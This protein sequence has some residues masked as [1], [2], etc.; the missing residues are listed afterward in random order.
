MNLGLSEKLGKIT[1]FEAEERKNKLNNEWAEAEEVYYDNVD[2][3][4]DQVLKRQAKMDEGLSPY[5][6]RRQA[7]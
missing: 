5:Y 1:A 7:Y 2:V 3:F 6:Q 4:K